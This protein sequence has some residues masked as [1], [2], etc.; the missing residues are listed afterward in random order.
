MSMSDMGN[1][2]RCLIVMFNEGFSGIIFFEHAEYSMVNA[3]SRVNFTLGIAIKLGT[4]NSWN[5]LM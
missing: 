4:L 3:I 2:S 5:N 1:V